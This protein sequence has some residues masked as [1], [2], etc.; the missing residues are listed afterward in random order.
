MQLIAGRTAQEYNQR[1][2]KQG[3]FWEDRYHATAVQADAH[4]HRCT[5]Y[6]DLN[7]VRT[8]VVNHSEK[9]NDSGFNKIQKPPKRYAIIDLQSL[10]ELSGFAKL[11]EIFKERTVTGLNGENF[12][13]IN[14]MSARSARRPRRF[15]MFIL[16]NFL[17]SC[18]LRPRG[19]MSVSILVAALPC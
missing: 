12:P 14:T 15:L 16:L 8:G 17:I 18:S 11:R 19:E 7:M 4:L 9:W 2:G 6:L 13:T 5:V 1:K 3:A 10:S